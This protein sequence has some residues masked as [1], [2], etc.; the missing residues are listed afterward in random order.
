M[1]WEEVHLYPKT[2][3]TLRFHAEH[4]GVCKQK[5]R[6]YRNCPHSGRSIVTF[7]KP[8]VVGIKQAQ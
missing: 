6:V 5:C 2:L 1:R 3:N 4:S 8:E 7:T